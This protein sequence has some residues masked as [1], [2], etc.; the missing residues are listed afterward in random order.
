[1]VPI[2]S[3]I[4]FCGLLAQTTALLQT[5]P[6]T[7]D[8]TLPLALTPDLASSPTDLAGTLMST[9]SNGLLSGNL[10]GTLKNLPLSDILKTKGGTSGGLIGGLLGRV[11]SGISSLG[12]IDLEITNPQLLEL[13]FVPSPDGHRLYVNIPLAFDLNVKTLLLGGSLLKLDLQLN[14]T[15]EILAVRNKQGEIHLVL[16]D[17]THSPGSLEISLLNGVGSLPIHNLIGNLRG[18]LTKVL[19][20]LVQKNVCPL[21]N[22]IL[23]NLDMTLVHDLVGE[24]LLRALSPP[25]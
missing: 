8:Q 6:L 20:M 19:P 15:A 2:G 7:L 17:C 3:L 12:I 14:I 11:T 21:V 9:L 10:L 23:K 22:D 5:P 25:L 4:V 13:G 16:G 1:M 24:Y 18:I